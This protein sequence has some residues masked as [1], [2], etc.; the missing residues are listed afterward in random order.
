VATIHDE[1]VVECREQ[2]AEEEAQR[3]PR[4]HGEKLA[5]LVREAPHDKTLR[6]QADLDR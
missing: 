4:A 1:I 6:L 3:G 5:M 2:D